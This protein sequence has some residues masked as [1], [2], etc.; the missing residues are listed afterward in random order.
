MDALAGRVQPAEITRDLPVA[1]NLHRKT[2]A[3]VARVAI[4]TFTGAIALYRTDLA[5]EI[6]NHAFTAL[7]FGL[8]AAGALAFGPGGRDAASR[9]IEGWKGE[10]E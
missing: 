1:G 5:P 9:A 3:A 10:Q 8:A 6:V 2:L 4:L 7:I